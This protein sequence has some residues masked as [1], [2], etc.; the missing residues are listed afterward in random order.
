MAH[1][2]AALLVAVATAAFLSPTEADAQTREVAFST[3]EGTWLSLDV[4]PGGDRLVFEL[5]GDIY[6]LPIAGGA[7][8][9][10]LTGT[11]FQSQPR[12]SPDGAWLAFI[13]DESGA[14]NLWIAR[15]DGSDARPVSDRTGSTFISPDWSVDGETLFVTVV[16]GAFQRVAELWAFEVADGAETRL[17]ENG[18]GPS[19]PLVSSPAP[20]PY[21]A[22]VAP[23]G[24]IYYTSVTPRPYGSRNGASSA[25][26]RY[27]SAV[28]HSTPVPLEGIQAM[29][30][31]VSPDGRTLVYAAMRD[32]RTGLKAKDLSAGT[33]RWIAYPIQRHQLEGRA[34]RDVL[35]NYAFTPDGSALLV[36]LRGRIQRLDLNTDEVT[37]VP[38]EA[39]VR[40]QVAERLDF[41][42]PV[43]TGPVRARRAHGIAAASS[44]RLAFS[45]LARIWVIEAVGSTPR[46]LTDE[47]RPREFMP[48]WSPDGRWIAYVTWTEEGG[49]LWKASAAGGVPERLS[50]APALWADPVWTP[51]GDAVIALRASLGAAASVPSLGP[52]TAVPPSADIVS[53][54]IDGGAHRTIAPSNGLRFPHFGPATD[55]VYLSSGAA[56][57]VRMPLAGGPPESV[58]TMSGAPAAELRI[59]PDGRFVAVRAGPAVMRVQMP[60]AVAAGPVPIAPEGP[61]LTSAGATSVAWT[62]DGAAL[63]WTEGPRVGRAETDGGAP[64][65]TMPLGVEVPRA[66]ATGSVV[67]S[68]AK[69]VTMR[70]DEVIERGDVVVTDGRISWVGPTGTRPHDDEARV[71]DLSGRVIVPGFIDVHAHF[72]ARGELLEPE[73]TFAFSNLA[74]GITTV[75]N[76]Q[77]PLDVFELADVI[78]ADGVPAPRVVSTGP[79]LFGMLNLQS[80]EQTLALL[81]RYRDEYGTHVLKS[82]LVGDRQQRAWVA[83]ASRELGMMPTTEGGADTK[84]D[85]THAIDGFSG[86]EHAVPVAPIYDDIVQLFARTGV[87]YTPTLVVSFGAALPIY[88]LLAEERPHEDARA[89][90]WHAEGELYQRSSTRQLWFAPEDFSNIEVAQGADAILAAGGNVALGGH[91]E[92]Q[93]LSNH[94]EM[95]LLA[96]GGMSNHDILRVATIMG[97]EAVGHE[98]DL[99]S[100]EVGKLADLVVLNRDPLTDIEATQDIDRVM[101]GGVLYDGFTLDEVWPTPRSRPVPWKLQKTATPAT[102]VASIEADVREAMD[103]TRTPGVAVAVVHGGD[104]LMSKGFGLANIETGSAVTPETMFQSGSVGKQFTAAGVMVLV[105]DGRVDLDE[106]IRTHLPEAPESWQPITVRHLLTHSSG[107]P[108]YT[109][110]SFDYAT[111]Y[112]E[113]D[114]VRMASDLTLEYP[115]GTRWN[116][117]NTGYAM[118]GVMISRV[119]GVPYWDFLR[120][121]VFDPAGMPTIRINTATEIVPHRARGYMPGPGGLQ[122]AS[123]VAEQTNTTADGSML[124]SLRDMIAWNEAV[125]TRTVLSPESWDQILSPMVLNSGN[126]HPYGFAWFFNEAAGQPVVEHGGSWQGFVNQYTRF[127]DQDLSVIVLTNARSTMSTP[128]AMRIGALVDPALTPEPPPTEAIADDPVVTAYVADMIEKMSD[129]SIELTDWDFVRQTVFPRMRVALQSQLD[130]LGRPD[131]LTLVARKQVGDD[132]E[133]VYRATWGDQRR[134][135]TLSI[136]PDGG[137]TNFVFIVPDTP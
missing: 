24:S 55:A 35:P 89:A 90:R 116:Y 84:A 50:D 103:R 59:S 102:A 72:G 34:T 104:V 132:T 79:G 88:R 29:K 91:G 56:G 126:T 100:I 61:P 17:V 25:V 113:D 71:I 7:A 130:G 52:G 114:L 53:I 8:R 111:N 49:H 135:I 70:G 26:M 28:G 95:K 107:I 1:R 9:P 57:L 105:E 27:D 92:V 110:A 51:D 6:A 87:T 133:F 21:G 23:D 4:S 14:D 44:G 108:D 54:P 60:V 38:F 39:A 69:I 73:G 131:D 65:T 94:W 12:Y 64:P 109:S 3:A 30:P 96:A 43:E 125:R 66:A 33:E 134:R 101:R 32:G 117:S 37:P 15:S 47:P 82:Y 63:L 97:A 62:P 80:Y 10:V 19:A 119:T 115:A 118:L 74:F 22:S 123:H 106:S 36:E 75:R 128:L 13:S 18:N 93:G 67:L 127:P 5:L 78:E 83:Q 42:R 68:G 48:A 77:A 41:P 16:T 76:P 45:S 124:F 120:E 58:A 122:N 40:L 2:G 31:R 98:S 136:G 11:A 46:R 86:N 99:G 81:S 112:S 137:L 129:G 85:L 20:G 121:R